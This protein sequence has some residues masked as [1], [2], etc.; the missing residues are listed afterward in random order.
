MRT[1]LDSGVLIAAARGKGQLSQRAL[2]V[3]TDESRE[4]VCSEYVRL[5]IIPKP[6]FFKYRAE[7][8]FYEACFA[9]VHMWLSYAVDHLERGF[10]EACRRLMRCTS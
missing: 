10:E 8:E 9:R 3:L 1:Y 7:I 2:A 5:E 4:F 6:T